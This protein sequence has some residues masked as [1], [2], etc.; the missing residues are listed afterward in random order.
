MLKNGLMNNYLFKYEEAKTKLK[1]FVSFSN[2]NLEQIALA[3]SGG[4]DST[5]VLKMIEDLGWKNK[6]KVVFCNTF[7]ELKPT[8]DFVNK[9]RS[10]GWVIDE[11][12]PS[13]PAPIIYKEDGLPVHSKFSS[14]MISRLQKHNFNF[15]EDIDKSYEF[16]IKKYPNAKGALKWLTK[17]NIMINCPSYLKEKLNTI[18]FKVSNKCCYYLKKNLWNFLTNKTT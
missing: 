11:T 10:E 16:L 13:K 6:I 4:K 12:R 14:D 8:L 15:N 9:K 17:Q 1:D 5:L 18:D 3:F 7:M 2:I